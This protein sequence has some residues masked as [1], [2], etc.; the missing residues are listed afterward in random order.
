MDELRQLKADLMYDFSSSD[1]YTV[2]VA[3]PYCIPARDTI[4]KTCGNYGVKILKYREYTKEA[5]PKQFIKQQRLQI[6]D[7]D[8]P[9]TLPMAQ[10]AEVTVS[11]KQ[12]RWAEYILLRTGSFYRV[13]KFF[14][15]RNESWARKHKGIMP[16]AWNEGKPMIERNCKEGL[17][18]WHKT[19][20]SRG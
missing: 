3:K 9:K 14:D 4:T 10:V 15:K 7:N 19:L 1:I 12:A 13:G 6:V 16:P 17:E 18:N 11:E 5:N 8:L 20:N 2:T